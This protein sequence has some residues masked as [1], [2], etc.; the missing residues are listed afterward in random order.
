M[1]DPDGRAL[2]IKKLLNKAESSGVTPAERDAFNAKAT[3]LMLK[4]GIEEAM[5]AD[6]DRAKVENI[7]QCHFQ[8]D[9]PK[10]YSYETTCIGIEVAEALG[11][12]GLLQKMRNGR[13]NL[14]V[15]GF[16]SDV[17]RVGELFTSL[18]VQATLELGTWFADQQWQSWRNATDRYNAKRSYLRGY[19]SGVKHKFASVK[20]IVIAE[21]APGTD[22]VL[23]SRVAQVDT[24]I[25]HMMKI[26]S[27]RPRRYGVN[28]HGAG[29]TAGLR[30]DIG[31]EKLGSNTRKIEGDKS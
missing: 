27:T 25:E 23:V 13:V 28:A 11:C 8:T 7:I 10:S 12:R 3:E 30:A 18:A 29:S 26:T 5:L 9:V 24:Y 20:V 21:S 2:T 4:W 14:T 1:T 31:G 15:V 22:L 19:A 17:A 16:E 6:A